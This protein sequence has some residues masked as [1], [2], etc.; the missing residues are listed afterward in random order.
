MGFG[1]LNMELGAKSNV[2]AK[3]NLLLEVI[4][5]MFYSI[6]G[7]RCSEAFQRLL[8]Y[9]SFFSSLF[10]HS[11]SPSPS[12]AALSQESPGCPPML[13]EDR[14][15]QGHAQHAHAE[16]EPGVHMGSV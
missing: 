4:P 6:A 15:R 11:F 9:P 14:S 16:V 12:M 8:K 3:S 7:M 10:P 13:R 5:K 2:K 1:L